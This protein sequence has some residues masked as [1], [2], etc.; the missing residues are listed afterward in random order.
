MTSQSRNPGLTSLTN[1]TSAQQISQQLR[2]TV[3]RAERDGV[4]QTLTSPAPVGDRDQVGRWCPSYTKW[5]CRGWTDQWHWHLS[6]R[7]EEVHIYSQRNGRITGYWWRWQVRWLILSLHHE[8]SVFLAAS[9]TF[10]R[11]S[12]RRADLAEN[13]PSVPRPGGAPALVTRRWRGLTPTDTR[14]PT[15]AVSR[16]A[17]NYCALATAHS[18]PEQNTSNDPSYTQRRM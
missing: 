18:R 2:V 15:Q 16:W 8:W 7:Q 11:P 1:M 6:T 5:W 13:V 9:D 10:T 17:V 12:I 4:F 3:E 14:V